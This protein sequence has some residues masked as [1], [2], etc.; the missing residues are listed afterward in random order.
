MEKFIIDSKKK[1][2]LKNFDPEDT[3]N[4]M[5]DTIKDEY[6]S[7]Q[8]S[9]LE[10]QN[11]FYASKKFALLIVLQ[12]MDCSGKDGAVKKIL[13]GI[14]PNGFNVKSFKQPTE[15]EL[16]HDYL[17]R[18]HKSSPSK[19]NITIF[20]RSYYEDVLITRVH[21][22]INDKT[23]F[24]R[25]KEIN[26]FEKYLVNNNI[27]VL[28]FFLHISKDFQMEKIKERLE[29]PSKQWKF[30]PSDLTERNFWNEYQQCYEDV[31]S[32]CSRKD[33]PWYII[34]SNNRWFRDYLILKTIVSTLEKLEL[35]FPKINGNIQNLLD[36]LKNSN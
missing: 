25:F 16:K 35:K 11:I 19:G 26:K 17:W 8:K 36:E 24:T 23:A 4:L 9:F 20:N 29:N 13:T 22:V 27:I 32:N 5:K 1:V 28:K 7:L 30:S 10:L 34:P 3:E 18:V 21:N 12:G 14:N 33:A 31:I 6:L 2:V 15:E